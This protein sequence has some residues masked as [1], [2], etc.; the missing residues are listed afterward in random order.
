MNPMEFFELN[1]IKLESDYNGLEF[2]SKISIEF[3]V[4]EFHLGF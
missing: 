3:N 4:F 1:S 2:Y